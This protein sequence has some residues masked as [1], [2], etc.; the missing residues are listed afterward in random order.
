MRFTSFVAVSLLAATGLGAPTLE[1]TVDGLVDTTILPAECV[2]D[3]DANNIGDIFRQLIQSYS[4]ELAL[5]ALTEDFVDY[6]SSVNIIIN[7]GADAPKNLTEPTFQ[8]RQAFMDGQGA[9]PEIPFTTLF[10]KHGCDF[11]SMRWMSTRSAAGQATEVAAEPVIGTVIMDVVEDDENS[12]GWRVSAIYSEFNSGAWL[13]NLGVFDPEGPTTPV[14]SSRRL[15][16]RS[17]DTSSK[18]A[19]LVAKRSISQGFQGQVL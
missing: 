12:Y 5:E 2:S 15:A 11:V 10:V 13:V 1:I 17:V 6:S 4:D 18:R 19:G 7:G 9:Q 14:P 16:R 3:D 8:G